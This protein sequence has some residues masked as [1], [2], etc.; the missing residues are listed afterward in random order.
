MYEYFRHLL[1]MKHLP[2]NLIEANRK[3]MQKAR[4]FALK[5]HPG[6][7]VKF[8]EIRE[9]YE[10]RQFHLPALYPKE[11]QKIFEIFNVGVPKKY[12]Q[13]TA[14]RELKELIIS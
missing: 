9:W 6:L 5:K 2:L 13:P 4:E 14:N 12:F 11:L 7:Q 8:K 3:S 10:G 1:T